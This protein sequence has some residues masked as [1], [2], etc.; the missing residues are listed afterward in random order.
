MNHG[1]QCK[2]FQPV[3]VLARSGLDAL[4][5][6]SA[7]EY[8]RQTDLLVVA[9]SRDCECVGVALD[10]AST[11]RVRELARLLYQLADE[12]DRSG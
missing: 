10:V 7:E 6:T 3:Q 1:T 9:W 2:G 5:V 4:R 8:G 11:A 12:R